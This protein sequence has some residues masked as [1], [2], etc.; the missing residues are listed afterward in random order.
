MLNRTRSQDRTAR[1]TPPK[2]T[3]PTVSR[4]PC[5][6]R[7]ASPGG[8]VQT[9]MGAP[10]WGRVSEICHHG[11]TSGTCHCWQGRQGPDRTADLAAHTPQSTQCCNWPGR[12]EPDR[13]ACLVVFHRGANGLKQSFFIFLR[14]IWASGLIPRPLPGLEFIFPGPMLFWMRICRV[15]SFLVV[16]E[17]FGHFVRGG[18]Y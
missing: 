3:C 9:F 13:T 7:R 17:G 11:C 12:Q 6:Y 15:I 2:A 8:S 1:C 4:T 14:R 10:S 5:L 18:N 16:F